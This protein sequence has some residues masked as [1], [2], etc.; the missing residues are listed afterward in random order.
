MIAID[1]QAVEVPAC[2]DV[3]RRLIAPAAD[4]VSRRLFPS[5][6]ALHEPSRVLC[7]MSPV[8]QHE[9]PELAP[10]DGSFH[11][12]FTPSSLAR[13]Q[14]RNSGWLKV[15]HVASDDG[16]SVLKRRRRYEKICAVVAECRGQL[17][18][19]PCGRSIDG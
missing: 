7:R 8:V 19:P 18:P 9:A 6:R 10:S 3:R 11:F 14:D 1:V 2:L 13:V 5:G 12:L 17:P 15:T 4:A 16:Q